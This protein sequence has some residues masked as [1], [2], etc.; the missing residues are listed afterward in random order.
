M[1]ENIA[2][3]IAEEYKL[4][5]LAETVF[6]SEIVFQ[7][8]I[9]Q[10]AAEKLFADISKFDQIE[11]WTLI[12][13]IL[14]STANVSK[15]LWPSENQYL[16]R[17]EQ[18]R[19]LLNVNIKNPLSKRKFRNHFEHY[20]DRIEK[21]FKDKKSSVYTD[22][23]MNPS[24]RSFWDGLNPNENRGYDQF[25][26]TLTFRGESTNLAEVLQELGIIILSCRPYVLT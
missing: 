24:M 10:R 13:T 5:P 11:I 9:A 18:L 23:M 7:I 26:K 4:D 21:W 25:T 14:V 17:G 19:K 22:N 20:D 6:L 8:K 16:S 15:I 3:S 1:E 2:N 12:Q